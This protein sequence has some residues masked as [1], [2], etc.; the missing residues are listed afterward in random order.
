MWKKLVKKR[1]NPTDPPK[2]YACIQDMYTIT[3]QGHIATGHGGRDRMLKYMSNKYTN[4]TK[5]RV[6][7]FKS[8]C[9]SCQ[10]KVKRPKTTRVIVRLILSNDFLSRS[11]VD[12]I[13]MQSSP[14]SQFHRIMVYQCQLT[15]F[16]ILRPLKSKKAVEVA[17]QNQ[18]GSLK[19]WEIMNF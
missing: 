13:D 16:C 2:Y 12:M 11:Q 6:D 7:L 19:K 8:F 14:Q 18:D 15:K 4:I 5:A 9:V 1:E 17:S 3:K 10:E